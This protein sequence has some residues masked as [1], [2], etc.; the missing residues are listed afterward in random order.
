MP[1]DTQQAFFFASSL[2]LG[3]MAHDDKQ[4]PAM[5]AG[6]AFLMFCAASLLYAHAQATPAASPK[7]RS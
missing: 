2:Y 7:P 5:R 4:H 1:F 3:H 6:A